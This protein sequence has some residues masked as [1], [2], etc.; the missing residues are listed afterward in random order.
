LGYFVGGLVVHSKSLQSK[1]FLTIKKGSKGIPYGRSDER[2]DGSKNHGFQALKGKPQECALIPEVQEDEALKNALTVL[3]DVG[4]QFFT[5]GCGSVRHKT[6]SGY[7]ME[8]YLEFS[9]N[10]A[11]LA[12]NAQFYLNLFFFFNHWHWKQKRDAGV[13]YRF[14]IESVFF[15]KTVADGFT[16]SVWINTSVLPSQEAA[17]DAWGW[18]LD[19]VVGFLKQFSIPFDGPLTPIY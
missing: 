15:A 10:Y 19:T 18:A 4:T 8:G 3:N 17:H 16:S 9:L 1:I 6:D 13:R 5:V 2:P 7:W 14:E 11:E 12:A